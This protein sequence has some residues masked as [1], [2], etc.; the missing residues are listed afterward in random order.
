M[1]RTIKELALLSV[2]HDVDVFAVDQ[3]NETPPNTS[4]PGMTRKLSFKALKDALVASTEISGSIMDAVQTEYD[5][6]TAAESSLL[7]AIGTEYT[8]ATGAEAT[9]AGNLSAEI[10][11]AQDSEDDLDDKIDLEIT[12]AI[13]GEAGALTSATT[14]INAE[15]SRA[16]SV[17]STLNGAITAEAGRASNT[18]TI[19]FSKIAQLQSGIDRGVVDNAFTSQGTVYSVDTFTIDQAGS[20]YEIDD[21]IYLVGATGR[22]PIFRVETISDSNEVATL[23][24]VSPGGSNA[25]FAG[26]GIATSTDKNGT[27]LTVDI[28]SAVTAKTTLNDI[29]DPIQ[30]SF[31]YVQADETHGGD[32]WKYSYSDIDG[33]DL[34]GWAP[35]VAVD[36]VLRDFVAEPIETNELTPAAVTDSIIGNRTIDDTLGA[37]T[38]NPAELTGTLTQLL[39]RNASKIKAMMPSFDYM[40]PKIIDTSTNLDELVR[41]PGRYHFSENF[42]MMQYLNLPWISGMSGYFELRVIPVIAGFNNLEVDLQ[43][44]AVAGI[45]PGIFTRYVYKVNTRVDI[46]TSTPI[47][48]IGTW[49]VRE[50][51]ANQWFYINSG[52]YTVNQEITEFNLGIISPRLYVIDT[53]CN[54]GLY[55]RNE[56]LSTSMNTF[57][58]FQTVYGNGTTSQYATASQLLTTAPNIL[59]ARFQH[60][61]IAETYIRSMQI[62]LNN[63]HTDEAIISSVM[64][65]SYL[66]ESNLQKNA[67]SLSPIIS[68]WLKMS[69]KDRTVTSAWGLPA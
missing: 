18:E 47:T 65:K 7:T 22:I 30:N 57:A 27:G 23:K 38:D 64:P 59:S 33:D 1:I 62:D 45:L 49:G 43:P 55:I 52:T 39:S 14:L 5:R 58:A 20:G 44:L 46:R 53:I 36:I 15:A 56:H 19:L 26:T 2:L 25:D 6:A 67:N 37:G 35:V 68:G 9:I 32:T 41:T 4:I 63:Y 31:V 42:A 17:E 24:L 50:I 51:S 54:C 40:L 66:W 29:V 48:S 13:Q 69:I 16:E 12:R 3:P 61:P 10:S 34:Y 60:Y 8:R 28:T 11:R 21:V